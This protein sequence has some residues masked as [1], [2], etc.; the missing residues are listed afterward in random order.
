M[1]MSTSACMRWRFRC[2]LKSSIIIGLAAPV[3]VSAIRPG[4][5]DDLM[6]SSTH[7]CGQ[8][9]PVGTGALDPEPQWCAELDAP[10]DQG[11]VAGAIG[12]EDRAA[13][14]DAAFIEDSSGVDVLMGIDTDHDST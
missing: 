12:I 14:Q 8:A 11:P 10:A 3:A 7:R 9:T 13:Q 2:C 5:L 6:T 4:H 1:T